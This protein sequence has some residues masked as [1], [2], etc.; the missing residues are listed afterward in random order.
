MF[1]LLSTIKKG[2]IRLVRKVKN[3]IEDGFGLTRALT[4]NSDSAINTSEII[5]E[6]HSLE[7]RKAHERCS[8]FGSLGLIMSVGGVFIYSVSKIMEYSVD[9]KYKTLYRR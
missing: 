4:D 8:E 6:E 3:F 2:V 9:R 5:D 7:Y 1:K